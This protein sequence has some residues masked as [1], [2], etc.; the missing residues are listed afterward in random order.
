[1][2]YFDTKSYHKYALVFGLN[3]CSF[4]IILMRHFHIN[5]NGFIA[6]YFLPQKSKQT[7]V[8]RYIFF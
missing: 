2:P 4:N 1:M 6:Y 5:E 8:I 7:T 3:N